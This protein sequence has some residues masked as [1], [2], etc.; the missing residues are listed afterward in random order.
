MVPLAAVLERAGRTAETLLRTGPVP[1][2]MA[3]VPLAVAERLAALLNIATA[4]GEAGERVGRA[5][6]RAEQYRMRLDETR[7]RVE[8]LE[9]ELRSERSRFRFRRVRGLSP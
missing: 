1:E 5:E 4:Y 3:L 2:G 6:E 8:A 9:A 7:A